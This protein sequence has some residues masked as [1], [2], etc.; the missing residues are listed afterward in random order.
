MDKRIQNHLQT[1]IGN[2]QSAFVTGRY[3]GD[4]IRLIDDILYYSDLDKK[5]GILFA[6]D[7]AAAFD[8][9][10]YNFIFAVLQKINFSSSF[11]KW[12]KLLH[13]NLESC[14][15]NNGM[16]TGYFTLERD[17]RQGDPLAPYLFL[18]VIEILATMVRDNVKT[19]RL[20]I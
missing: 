3:I 12:V 14:V 2:E 6:A 13:Q 7:F 20:T 18:L 8:S 10:D 1:I 9:V 4:S 17:T 16:L 19:E 15:L 5:S 11:I